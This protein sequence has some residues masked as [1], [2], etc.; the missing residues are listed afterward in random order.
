MRRSLIEPHQRSAEWSARAWRVALPAFERRRSGAAQ[1]SLLR[2]D[3]A[4]REEPK[5]FREILG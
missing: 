3:R 1:L 2:G 5:A 4:D